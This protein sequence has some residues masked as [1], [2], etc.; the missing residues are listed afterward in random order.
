MAWFKRNHPASVQTKVSPMLVYQTS[1]HALTLPEAWCAPASPLAFVVGYV[2]PHVDIAQ[3]GR[4][5]QQQ[6]G[7]VPLVLTSTAGELCALQRDQGIYQDTPAHGWQHVVLQGFSSRLLAQVQVV[8]IPLHADDLRQGQVRLTPNERVAKIVHELDRV[9][10]NFPINVED[11]VAFTLI[12]GLSSSENYFMQ[13]IYQ[14]GKFPLWF[15]GGSAGGKL[16]FSSTQI[17]A[18]GKVFTGQAVCCF[19]KIQP[20]YRYSVFKSQNFSV[21]PQRFLIAQASSELRFVRSIMDEQQRTVIDF[22]TALCQYFHCAEKDLLNHLQAYS[23]AVE[24]GHELF[25]R[26]V[27]QINF[28]QRTVHFACDVGSGDV[29]ILVKMT[30]LARQTAQDLQAFL[31]NKG[32]P[33]GA[34]FNDCILRRLNNTAQ[35]AQVRLPQD[36]PVAGFSTFGE[37]LGININQTLTGL[38]FF[39]NTA[40]TPDPMLSY[41]AVHYANCHAYFSQRDL[42][43]ARMMDEMKRHLLRALGGY[44]TAT[45]ELVENLPAVVQVNE[46][47][48]SDLQRIG[49][50]IVAQAQ[51]LQQEVQ[52]AG[53][54]QQRLGRLQQD[55]V[56]VETIL[57]TIRQIAEQTNLLALNAAIEA[58]RAGEAGRGF[59]VVADEVRKLA[60]NTQTSLQQTSNSI[61]SMRV[62]V[63]EVGNTLQYLHQLFES[64]AGNSGQ[65]RDNLA[66]VVQDSTQVR[67]HVQHLI[68]RTRGVTDS[69]A[70][71]E[72]DLALLAL[73]EQSH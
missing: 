34:I 40:T 69:A 50:V 27:L 18:H 13:A 63:T 55:T 37:L 61:D 7:N 60:Q 3:V 14:S 35:L 26:S 17:F 51:S 66:A 45:D 19:M 65:M 32:K 29:L 11:S 70:R 33:V 52:Q 46:K 48:A 15:I 47:L 56:Q 21:T 39:E 68:S 16:D 71:L 5:L 36:F 49:G 44:K 10:L 4:V 72:Q 1:A 43:R 64:L 20:A 23:F 58:A 41:F 28:E 62:S 53:D 59:A 57:A 73:L 67:D 24:I 2:S 31:Q 9:T 38:F 42:Q 8:N 54:S 25:I 6:L 30:D 12:D 22:I